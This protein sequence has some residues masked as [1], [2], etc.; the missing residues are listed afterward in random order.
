MP[1]IPAG[2]VLLA[3]RFALMGVLRNDALLAH[4][5]LAA[6]CDALAGVNRVLGRPDGPVLTRLAAEVA[7]DRQLGLLP[8]AVA[9]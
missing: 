4:A 6:C 3:A 2:P 7:R 1:P 5:D 9:W 8:P